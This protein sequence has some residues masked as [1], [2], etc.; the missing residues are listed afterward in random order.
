MPEQDSNGW[1]ERA[2]DFD[3]RLDRLAERH[4][5]LSETVEII[6]GMQRVNDEQIGELIKAQRKNEIL[7]AEV[8]E[9]INSLGR[10]AQ[11][12]EKRIDDLE[13]PRS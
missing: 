11:S 13:G 8:I 4:Q 3:R 2:A 6:A 1:R 7:L 10:I 12:H 9:A 5:A